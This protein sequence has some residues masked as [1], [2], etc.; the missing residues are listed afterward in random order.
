MAIVEGKQLIR[1][2]GSCTGWKQ[3][4]SNW[5]KGEKEEEHLISENQTR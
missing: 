5:L 3:K 4:K 1:S 2:I